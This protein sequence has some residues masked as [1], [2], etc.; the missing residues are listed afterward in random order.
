MC[1][2]NPKIKFAYSIYCVSQV[3]FRSLRKQMQ[4]MT[5]LVMRKTFQ[6]N[7]Q[8]TKEDLTIIQNLPGN[9]PRY[10]NDPHKIPCTLALNAFT[11][12]AISPF[13]IRKFADLLK[14]NSFLFLIIPYLKRNF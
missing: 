3:E 4:L 10:L 12:T 1:A 11:V 6:R 13:N 7:V 14:S 2:A 9:F 5:E 8:I